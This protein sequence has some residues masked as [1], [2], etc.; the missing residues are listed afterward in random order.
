MSFFLLLQYE[1]FIRLMD[2]FIGTPHSVRE[3]QFIEKYRV[4]LVQ[5]V[6]VDEG[7]EVNGNLFMKSLK[8]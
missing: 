3:S 4:K 1:Q 7:L 8:I 5:K 2:R 6:A